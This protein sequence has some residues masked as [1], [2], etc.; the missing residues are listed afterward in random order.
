MKKL[1]VAMVRE[2]L[3]EALDSALGGEPV[4]IERKG[5]TYRLSVEPAPKARKTRQ[6]MLEVLDPALLDGRWTWDWKD[7]QLRFRSRPQ[8]GSPKRR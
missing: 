7:G 1:T 2:R 8:S 4:F 6:P 5:V 3:S